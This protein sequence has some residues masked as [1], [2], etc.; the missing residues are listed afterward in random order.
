MLPEIASVPDIGRPIEIFELQQGQ[1]AEFTVTD[2][3][4]G[5][6]KIVPR[7]T[8][9]EKEVLILRL[10]LK[11]GDKAT[12]PSYWDLTSTTA[13]VDLWGQLKEP[14]ALPRKVKITKIGY[15]KVGRY[16]LELRPA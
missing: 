11:Q 10:F 3:A 16:A 13:I 6:G 4:L 14:G 2:I 5:K 15:G 8:R 1:S 9:T 12:S 7:E